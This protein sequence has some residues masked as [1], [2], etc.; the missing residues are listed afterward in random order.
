MFLL[1][2][3]LILLPH[4]VLAEDPNPIKLNKPIKYTNM[5]MDKYNNKAVSVLEIEQ[6]DNRKI[7]FVMET[8]FNEHVCDVS[9]V[10]RSKAE[11]EKDFEF[12]YEKCHLHLVFSHADNTITSSD[13]ERACSQYYCGFNASLHGYTFNKVKE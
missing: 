10:A 3:I 6:I 4:T 12:V 9:G 7:K 2:I 13:P 5:G 11:N 8:V 1:L